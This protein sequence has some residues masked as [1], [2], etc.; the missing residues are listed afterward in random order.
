M[1]ETVTNSGKKI[2]TIKEL[3]AEKN[4]LIEMVSSTTVAPIELV[5]KHPITE[6]IK[7]S[8]IMKRII[9]IKCQDGKIIQCR[10]RKRK[11]RRKTTKQKIR[12][13]FCSAEECI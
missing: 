10:R 11:A 9:A 7:L 6:P 5:M 1:P 12:F 4:Y 13:G 8:A 3:Q 2:A